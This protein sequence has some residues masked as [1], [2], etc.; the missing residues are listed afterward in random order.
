M[1]AEVDWLEPGV[2][3]RVDVLES[4]EHQTQQQPPRQ[5]A[6]AARDGHRDVGPERRLFGTATNHGGIGARRERAHTIS[7]GQS[8]AS[9]PGPDT[10]R[11]TREH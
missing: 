7:L 8:F 1:A 6:E 5:R 11:Q 3:P 4:S 9:L 10:P 2:R